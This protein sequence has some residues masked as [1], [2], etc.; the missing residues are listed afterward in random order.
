LK[1]NAIS[2]A[3]SIKV[4]LLVV[5]IS[6]MVIALGVLAG[7]SN[8]FAKQALTASVNETARALGTDCGHQ[9]EAS[10]QG[11][12]GYLA[13]VADNPYLRK[14]ND[15]AQVIASL[16][17][18][19]QANSQIDVLMFVTLDGLATRNDQTTSNIRERDYF[20]QV[21]QTQKAAVSD[22]IIS[23]ST[24]ELCVVIAVPVM[25]NGKMVA[26]LTGSVG[27]K[28]LND[29]VKDVKFKDTGYA[30]I[31]DNSGQVIAHSRNPEYIGKLNLAEKKVNSDLKLGI[32]ELDEKL[33]SQFKT[34]SESGKQVEGQYTFGGSSFVSVFTPINLPG[35]QRWV[36]SVSAP[37]TEVVSE[38]HKL[39][40]M[41]IGVT[42][43]CL[44][45]SIIVVTVFGI[46]FAK[47]VSRLRDEAQLLA[48]GDLRKRDTG[49]ESGDEIGQLAH[50]F[51]E[52]AG[53][54]RALVGKVQ[55]K[56]ETLAAA[57]EELTA[58]AHQGADSSTQVAGSTVQIALGLDEQ[59]KAVTEVV[60]VTD[61][62]FKSITKMSEKGKEIA[63]IA[64][65]TSQS[66]ENGHQAITSAIT[67]MRTIEEG[68][69]AV[70]AAIGELAAGSREIG[71]IVTL[72][73]SIAGQT[74]L[75]ALNAAIEAARA[76]EAG[77]GFAVVAEEV[78]KL[79][80]QSNQAAQ[81]ITALIQKN[82]V[83][84]D[85]A[86]EAAEKSGEGVKTGI[87][88][89][90]FAGTT[91]RTI[92]EDVG[93]LSQEI[94][95]ITDYVEQLALASQNLVTNIH[96]IDNISKKNAFEAQSVSAATE[97]QS[98]V[99]EEIAASSNAL[100]QTA[101]E[102]NVAVTNYRV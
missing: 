53:N 66:S 63:D 6:L 91:F 88:G 71:E 55:T 39:N 40:Y 23:G 102:M 32:S 99:M 86:I 47:P 13:T 20:K 25:D 31:V 75:L 76:G 77:R 1:F 5:T 50:A 28:H 44:V 60:D 15:K 87:S 27:L 3:S 17:E 21:L 2:M 46:R 89:V 100:A 98:A 54:L 58:N 12:V 36:V 9:V 81:E 95:N 43:V 70:Q 97:E 92:A 96:Q 61:Q 11:L 16:K 14:G 42:L 69:Q 56:A 33:I 72:I 4:K 101:E 64:K 73:S 48:G 24:G 82:Q 79:A 78:R 94:K 49:I 18:A 8:F 22:P 74:N 84:M 7:L 35:N 51:N 52:M 26:V 45:L 65:N 80:E 57:S 85:Q 19:K 62:M 37:E 67:Q 41:M 83:D 38:V 93:N 90:E 29:I 10:V 59:T 30:Y 68:A 34:A